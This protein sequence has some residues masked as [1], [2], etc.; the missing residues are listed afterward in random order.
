LAGQ[1]NALA[2][3]RPILGV[4]IHSEALSGSS[5]A[6][7]ITASASLFIALGGAVGAVTVLIPQLRALKAKVEGVHDIVNSQRSAMVTRINELKG[8][9]EAAHVP[10]P[11]NHDPDKT[12]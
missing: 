6:G 4:V 1:E 10:V 12:P 5:V 7:I 3:Q 11:E 2:S 9:L 8:A